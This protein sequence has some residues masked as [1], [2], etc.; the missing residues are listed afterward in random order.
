M[1][2]ERSKAIDRIRPL[3]D[4]EI[5]DGLQKNIRALQQLGEHLG[6]RTEEAERH[7]AA[8]EIRVRDLERAAKRP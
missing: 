1:N 6:G 4:A 7:I 8:L 2:T 3:T 5:I